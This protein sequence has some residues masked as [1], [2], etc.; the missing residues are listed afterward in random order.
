M[1]THEQKLKQ[2]NKT[3]ETLW[4]GVSDTKDGDY[5]RIVS[6]YKEV[7]K[8]NYKDRDAWET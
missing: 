3:I 6:L 1:Q 2:L 7:L 5:P 8:I 4:H